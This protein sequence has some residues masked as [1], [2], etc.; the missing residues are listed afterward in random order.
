[1]KIHLGFLYM[2]GIL[3]IFL[4]LAHNLGDFNIIK[5][6]FNFKLLYKLV[7]FMECLIMEDLLI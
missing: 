2:E 1:M 7:E 3:R 4:Y 5:N 6:I